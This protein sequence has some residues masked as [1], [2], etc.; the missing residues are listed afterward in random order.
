MPYLLLLVFVET[1][2]LIIC[3]C[4][5]A[6]GPL[7]RQLQGKVSSYRERSS[8]QTGEGA[9]GVKSASRIPYSGSNHDQTLVTIGGRSWKNGQKAKW[10]RSDGTTLDLSPVGSSD[11]IPLAQV[12]STP[13][14]QSESESYSGDGIQKTTK[15]SVS[16][17]RG[18]MVGPE[19]VGQAM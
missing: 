8:K 19:Q 10:V 5:P 3:A 7:V 12:D 13:R 15:I 17:E 16:S 1:M 6:L 9:T 18:S 4:I 2:V 11:E 14:P